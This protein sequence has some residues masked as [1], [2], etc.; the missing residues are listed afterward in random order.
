[1]A[2]IAVDARCAVVGAGRMGS[3]LVAASPRFSGPFGRGFDGSGFSAVLLAVPDRAIP[4]AAALI[5]PNVV[6]G[7]CAGALGLTALGDRPAF[8]VHPLMT[9][10]RSGAE[11]AGAGAAVAGTSPAL[12]QYATTI[13]IELGMRPVEIADH[14]RTAYHAAACIASNFLVALEDAAEQLLA[15]TGADRSILAPI[16]RAAVENWA[17]LGGP[18]ALTGP[19][20]RRDDATVLTQRNAVAERAPQLLEWFDASCGITAALRDRRDAAASVEQ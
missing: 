12:L 8:S 1:M 4:D 5:H 14:D 6:V 11:F 9:V 2:E 18:A 10:T 3:A 7:H 13:A 17:T 20:S 16:V 19:I 15:T